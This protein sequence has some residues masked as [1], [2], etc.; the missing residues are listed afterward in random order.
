MLPPPA[1]RWK[2]P[3]RLVLRASSSP[4][5][6]FTSL[7]LCLN[8][9]RKCHCSYLLDLLKIKILLG[10]CGT[11]CFPNA[12]SLCETFRG[13]FGEQKAMWLFPSFIIMLFHRLQ[14][15][16]SLYSGWCDQ[17]R[18]VNGNSPFLSV[19]FALATWQLKKGFGRSAP[20]GNFG[21]EPLQII[22]TKRQ[23]NWCVMLIQWNGP[24]SSSSHVLL[25]L[26]LSLSLSLFSLSP[27]QF[28]HEAFSQAGKHDS[29]MHV[30]NLIRFFGVCFV[31]A[32]PLCNI[33]S[34]LTVDLCFSCV[35]FCWCFFIRPLE[36]R[37]PESNR[38]DRNLFKL[39]RK[40]TLNSWFGFLYH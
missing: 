6:P 11:N 33:S 26:S 8:T 25:F 38:G 22:F 30:L 31:G 32:V 5:F 37:G 12:F 36:Y 35:C 27:L 23:V 13:K 34:E 39:L 16:I 17:S 14:T 2:A 28:L 29:S 7:R 10:C 18:T 1:R 19:F 40:L 3:W 20:L 9:F 21:T 4:W 15:Y 24:S